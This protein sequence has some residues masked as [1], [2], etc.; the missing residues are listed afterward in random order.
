MPVY[1][2]IKT[3]V[4]IDKLSYEIEQEDAI[5]VSLDY[6]NHKSNSEL[7]I[8]FVSDLST[9]EETTLSGIVDFHDG[10]PFQEY[11]NDLDFYVNDLAVVTDPY[12][13]ISGTFIPMQVLVHAR[14]LFNDEDNALYLPDFQPI[15]GENGIL[16]DHSNDINNI[17]SALADNGWYTQYIKS[18]T[19]PSPMDLLIYYGWLNSFNSAENSWNNELVAQDMAKYNYLIFGDGVQNPAHGDYS[20]TQTI[21]PRVQALNQR[22]KIFGYV[23][24]NQTIVNFKTKVDQWETLGVDG[25][26]IDEAGYD[27]GTT[28]S[29][30]NDM[31]DYVHDQDNA[32]IC[33]VNAWNLD[34]ILGTDNDPSYP[35][36][37]YNTTSGSSNLTE[38]DWCL[39]ESF[40]INTS[41][42]ISTGGY[43]GKAEW[44]NRGLAASNKRYEYGINLAG[45]GVIN[46][47]N[48]NGQDLFNFGFVSAMMWNLDVYGTSDTY[49]GASS[50]SVHYWDRP[51]TEGLGR[52]WGISPSVQ[53]DLVDTDVYHRYLDY[54]RLSLDF[55]SSAQEAEIKKFTPPDSF[56]IRFNAG[57]LT[58]GTGTYPSK[59]TASGSPITGLGY[60]D[61]VE[62]SMYDA[63][64]IPTKWMEGT[65]AE[66]KIYFFNDYSQTDIKVCRWAIDY[67]VY[68]DLEE[69]SNKT[70]T[71][72]TIN[73]S[74]PNNANADTFI[75]AETSMSYNDLNNPLV[76]NGTVMFRIYR[77]CTNVA[78]TMINDAILVLLVFEFATEVI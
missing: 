23:T 52:E 39:L 78:D 38:D 21:I 19:Y 53:M 1:N 68:S 43:E 54:G 4:N 5:T 34:H 67:Q 56:K 13:G 20:N 27:Y 47:D 11:V 60:D 64:E 45:V 71:T 35:N 18:W 15:L 6:I 46:N 28:R 22:A 14:E 57:D 62:E 76:R 42:F 3:T 36:S 49:Y 75:K 2:Y 73:K 72:L 77:D 25:I 17:T 8:C 59:T 50:A 29:G 63:F 24:A 65:D 69:L 44:A 40:P 66:I 12:T 74:L 9:P 55:S 41:A 26:F 32:S 48:A 70:T 10:Q 7:N 51:R 33:F 37:T 31:V 58:E 16:Q 61:T 30:F